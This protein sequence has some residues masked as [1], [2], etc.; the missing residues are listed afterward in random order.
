MMRLRNRLSVR[1]EAGFGV[2]E[3]LTS[4]AVLGFFFATFSTVVSSSLRGGGDIQAQ[5]VLQTEARAAV[6]AL[7]A[8]FRQATIAGDL[9]L[10][11]VS[12]ANSTQLTFLSPDR[13]Q[14]LHLRRIAYQVT[15][16]QLQRK[17]DTSTNTAAPWTIPSLATWSTVANSIKSTATPVF[18]YYD[19]NGATTTVAANVR[20]VRIRVSIAPYSAPTQVL[21]YDTRVALRPA[22]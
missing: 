11:R 21:E 13:T 7:V 14:P 3:M 22:A 20:S 17:V 6:D 1:S 10:A 15:G 19:V 16:G 18:T 9:T 12:T 4:I 2:I 5:A 8:D